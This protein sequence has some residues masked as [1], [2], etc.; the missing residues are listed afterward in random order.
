MIAPHAAQADAILR[1]RPGTR[2]AAADAPGGA[3]FVRVRHHAAALRREIVGGD[4]VEIAAKA[5]QPIWRKRG[6]GKIVNM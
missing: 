4:A 1:V 6:E 2:L 5:A 3:E